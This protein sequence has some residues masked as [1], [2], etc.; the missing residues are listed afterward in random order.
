VLK[1]QKKSTRSNIE[2]GAGPLT[3]LVAKRDGPVTPVVK[4]LAKKYG[5]TPAQVD[6][7]AEDPDI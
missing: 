1:D 7:Q 2:A 3:P 6:S 4:E 5:K